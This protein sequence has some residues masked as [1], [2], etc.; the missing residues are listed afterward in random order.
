MLA[1]KLRPPARLCGCSDECDS[2]RMW[3]ELAFIVKL[4]C[5]TLEDFALVTLACLVLVLDLW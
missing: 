1:A 2:V 5:R 3:L 4:L